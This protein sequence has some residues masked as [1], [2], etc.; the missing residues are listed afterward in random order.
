M[1][2][3]F[4]VHHTAN[5]IWIVRLRF[6]PYARSDRGLRPKVSIFELAFEVLGDYRSS[7]VCRAST[8]A[9]VL[10]ERSRFL[11]LECMEQIEPDNPK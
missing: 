10:S 9:N 8:V 11:L 1:H 6:G 7:A 4:D 5:F 2:A 3:Y